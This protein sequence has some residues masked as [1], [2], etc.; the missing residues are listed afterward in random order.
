MPFWR[1]PGRQKIVN[2]IE[3][4]LGYAVVIWCAYVAGDLHTVTLYQSSQARDPGAKWAVN[5]F[6]VTKE[7]VVG[8]A[9]LLA[10]AVNNLDHQD[11]SEAKRLT[12]DG[13]SVSARSLSSGF[14]SAALNDK[15]STP[16]QTG[17]A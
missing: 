12:Y 1:L 13:I 8:Q 16:A 15:G 2:I 10:D 14:G 6:P 4:Q 17:S 7:L 3:P 9:F 11:H 5:V